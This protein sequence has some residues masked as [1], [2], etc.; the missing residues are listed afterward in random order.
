MLANMG[1]NMGTKGELT[2]EVGSRQVSLVLGS[3]I[4]LSAFALIPN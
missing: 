4:L 2:I 1:A 3:C